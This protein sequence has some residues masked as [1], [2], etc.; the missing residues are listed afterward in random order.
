M[1]QYSDVRST[2]RRSSGLATPLRPHG[3]VHGPLARDHCS[4]QRSKRRVDPVRCDSSLVDRNVRS[5]TRSFCTS[6]PRAWLTVGRASTGAQPAARRV[7][8]SEPVRPDG[9][10]VDLPSVHRGAYFFLGD[11]DPRSRRRSSHSRTSRSPRA[12]TA[13]ARTSLRTAFSARQTARRSER[14]HSV[15]DWDLWRHQYL[16]RRRATP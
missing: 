5:P 7:R 6:T 15:A 10:I 4:R 14:R 13:F 8:Q 1:P 9:G 2:N 16:V 12:Y 3:G 11:A